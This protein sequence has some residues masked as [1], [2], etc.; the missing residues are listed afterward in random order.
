MVLFAYVT[1]H[2]INHIPGLWSLEAMDAARKVLHWPWFNPVGVTI[3]YGSFLIHGGLA[4]YALYQRRRLTMR[5]GEA[6]QMLFG[7]SLPLL[8][9]AH[10]L[11]TRIAFSVFGADVNYAYVLLAQWQFDPWIGVRQTFVLFAAW[12]HGCIGVY[13]WLRLKP[14]YTQYE[15]LLFG[16]AIL[17]PALSLAGFVRGSRDALA[18]AADPAWL[19]AFQT[20]IRWPHATQIDTLQQVESWFFAAFCSAIIGVLILRWA[21]ALWEKRRGFIE[22]TYDDGRKVRFPPGGSIL[23]L[24]R[25]AGIPHASVCGGRGRCSTCRVRVTQGAENLPPPDA[26]EQKVLSRVKASA[27]VRLACQT[28]PR[29]GAVDI[30]RLLPATAQVKDG[31]SKP[32]YIQGK[33]LDVTI[34]FADIRA[35]TQLSEDKLP[36]DVVFMLNRYFEC[37]GAAIT[38]SGGYLDKFIGDG[39]MAI[40]GIDDGPEA[41]CRAAIRASRNMFERLEELNRMLQLDLESPIRIGVGLHHGPAIVGEMGFGDATA[42][43]AIGDTVNTASRLESMTKDFAAQIV[44]SETVSATGNIDLSA[45]ERR[46]ADIR[47]RTGVIPVYAIVNALDLQEGESKGQS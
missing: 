28:R 44:V 16:L 38:E 30:M 13:Y 20:K 11:G 34:M 33:E 4:F 6:L 15:P 10:M 27:Q 9:V 41:G 1:L 26:S 25:A 40:F 35:F 18:L 36:Y 8:L 2:L 37:A 23:D 21:R 19:A 24:S 47:G 29:T 22:L 43:T 5:M 42:I 39:V 17:I 31:F 12:V 45:F 3:L 46:D 14:G 32:D 7:L